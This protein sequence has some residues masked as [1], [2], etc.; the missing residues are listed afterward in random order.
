VCDGMLDYARW[1]LECTTEAKVAT[2]GGLGGRAWPEETVS[3]G[4]LQ[5][6]APSR[7]LGDREQV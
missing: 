2:S 7:V 5:N 3:A 1:G 6:Q 4:A